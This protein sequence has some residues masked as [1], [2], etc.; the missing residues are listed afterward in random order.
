MENSEPNSSECEAIESQVVPARKVAITLFAFLAIAL[1][2]TWA[3]GELNPHLILLAHWFPL[4]LTFFV[5]FSD[6]DLYLSLFLGYAV[7]VAIFWCAFVFRKKKAFGAIL[8]IYI[9]ILVLNIGSCA[10]LQHINIH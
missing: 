7:Y 9:L 8:V 1:L 3:T 5:S 6:P 2:V 4:G 10:A